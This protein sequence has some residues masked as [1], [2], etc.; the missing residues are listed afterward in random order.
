MSL[1]FK[2]GCVCFFL[3]V[4]HPLWRLNHHHRH[5]QAISHHTWGQEWMYP[6][7]S[8][9]WAPSLAR[10]SPHS[11]ECAHLAL[12]FV[13]FLITSILINL[14]ATWTSPLV[15]SANPLS[16]YS[17]PPSDLESLILCSPGQHS[18]SIQSL[19]TLPSWLIVSPDD[20]TERN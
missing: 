17:L 13:H 10:S 20:M 14:K 7:D 18:S 12:V 1:N 15:S 4:D 2:L 19:S 16:I 3:A 11:T 8:W 5:P 6:P 9:P